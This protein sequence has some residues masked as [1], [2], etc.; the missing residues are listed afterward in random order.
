MNQTLAQE[1]AALRSIQ[2]EQ[3]LGGLNR[4]LDKESLRVTGDGYL[5]QRPHPRSLGSALTHTSITTD[6]SE[7]LLEFI[8]PVFTSIE[9]PLQF[10]TDLHS[11]TY[12]HIGDELLWV[13]S[14]PCILG[15]NDNIPIA[16]YGSSNVGRMKHAYRRGLDYRYGRAM[17]TIA[18]IHYNLSFPT[19]FWRGLQRLRGDTGPLQNFIS[20]QYFAL[21]RN[22]L[23][24]IGLY[25]YLYGASPAVCGSFVKDQQHQLD[26]LD[27]FTLF[28]RY[29]TSLRMS[30]L[31]YHNDAQAGLNVNYNSLAEYVR[32][33]QYA[34]RTPY[35][36]YQSFGLKDANNEYIQ[37]N[38][39]ILQ[40]ENEFYSSIRPKRTT[41]SGERP[42]CALASRGVEYIEMRCIDLNPFSPVG[43]DADGIRFLDMFALYC[44]LSDSPAMSQREQGCNLHN[45]QTIVT[46]G[47]NPNLQLVND[48][49]QSVSFHTWAQQHLA[50]MAQVAQLFDQAYGDNHYQQIIRQ[51]QDKLTDASKTPSAAII[52]QLESQQLSF[53]EFARGCAHD[54]RN[55]FLQQSIAPEM[56][57]KLEQSAQQS[58][59][60]QAEM[61]A[62]KEIDFDTYVANFFGQN[63]ELCP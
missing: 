4:G 15:G 46:Q 50:G 40:I 56:E 54:H 63:A 27:D 39:N 47:R 29:G 8:T 33:L 23:R 25:V 35:P 49:N 31:G 5:S 18:G 42:T 51:Q 37:L 32:T 41:E 2:L 45:L 19:S 13:N 16:K 3:E 57:R 12:Q 1:L 62:Q 55:H 59:R 58:L 26:K 53:F 24:N 17:Q 36:P 43:I 60:Q 20:E 21:I 6:Y 52:H 48:C 38:T 7:A 10:L 9:E 14:M 30:D 22:F 44:L 11:F 34:I 61:E 28:L